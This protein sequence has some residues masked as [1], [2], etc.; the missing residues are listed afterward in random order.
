MENQ[1]FFHMADEITQKQG[2]EQRE[3]QG[4]HHE[5][6]LMVANAGCAGLQP[7]VAA[8]KAKKD[9]CLANKETLIAGGPYVLPLAK[10]Y[11]V[12][13]LPADSEH[14]VS[15]RS[16]CITLKHSQSRQAVG[17]TAAACCLTPHVGHTRWIL[18]CKAHGAGLRMHC[19]ARPKAQ[20]LIKMLVSFGDVCLVWCSMWLPGWLQAIFQCIQGLPEGGLRRIILTASGGAFRDW[21]VEKLKEVRAA[22]AIKHPN[23]RCALGRACSSGSPGTIPAVA[24]VYSSLSFLPSPSLQ[25]ER[26]LACHAEQALSPHPGC[27]DHVQCF[28]CLSCE[29]SGM[30]TLVRGSPQN[31]RKHLPPGMLTLLPGTVCS[32]GPKITC[33]SATLMNKG[34]EVIEAHYLYGASYDDI[35]IVIH[36]QSIIH[37]MVETQDSSVLAQVCRCSITGLLLGTLSSTPLHSSAA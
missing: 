26:Y 7:T 10:E 14:S 15:S 27:E 6:I 11:G 20:L 17:C 36:P 35:E 5:R 32:M 21:P 18:G 9:I 23:W 16:A 4:D 24:A 19:A 1:G 12:N 25:K 34:L 29:G 22:D 31:A 37:S 8:I 33:D 28:C 30:L 13:I 3:V 2:A